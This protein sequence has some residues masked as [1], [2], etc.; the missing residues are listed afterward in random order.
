M[1]AWG[2]I[3]L[4][5]SKAAGHADTVPDMEQDKSAGVLHSQ[6]G[7]AEITEMIRISFLIHQVRRRE[8]ISN[9]M[10]DDDSNRFLVFVIPEHGESA[11]P[12]CGRQ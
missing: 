4:L 3:V 1:Q 9:R 11:A 7:L 10:T 6:R 12:D 8:W 5:V 2:L